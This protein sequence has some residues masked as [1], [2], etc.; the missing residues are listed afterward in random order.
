[1]KK[2]WICFFK[3]L[4]L[5]VIIGPIKI[6]YI[7]TDHGGDAASTVDRET[8]DS[9]DNR[10]NAE[11]RVIF[12]NRAQPPVPKFVNNRISTAKYRLVSY[13]SN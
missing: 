8:E 11:Q 6:S 4:F 3:K 9:G 5:S 12:I 2:I 1:M 7:V 13:T 10:A